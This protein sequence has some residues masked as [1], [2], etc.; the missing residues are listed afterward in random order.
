MSQHAPWWIAGPMLGLIVVGLLWVANKPLGALGGYVELSDQLK[1][2]SPPGFRVWFLLG[3][4][5]GGF[6]FALVA[7]G[8]RLATGYGH[9][10]DIAGS[11]MALQALVLAV[12]GGLIGYG[13]RMAGGC[14]SGH[15][16]CGVSYAR[17]SSFV[18]TMTFMAVAIA[19]RHL[20]EAIARGMR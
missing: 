14:T 20:I 3:I 8:P 12:A 7:G 17:V 10:A 6:V 4:V 19:A 5:L 15:G 1:Q 13:A 18:A 11:S 2:R 16:I 9:I